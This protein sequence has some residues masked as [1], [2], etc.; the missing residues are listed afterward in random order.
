VETG[1]E[2]PEVTRGVATWA[3]V[4]MAMPAALVMPPGTPV[5]AALVVP[6]G[7][8]VPT[9]LVVPPGTPV[10]A[11]LVVPPGTSVPTALVVPPMAVMR[12]IGVRRTMPTIWPV[13]VMPMMAMVAA[14][15]GLCEGGARSDKKDDRASDQDTQHGLVPSPEFFRG[16]CHGPFTSRLI[17]LEVFCTGV[18]VSVV[19]RRA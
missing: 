1:E 18:L 7:T 3:V 16:L 17:Y 14:V 5:P 6:P 10:P 8:S 4:A 9:A 11:A 19:P 2:Y 13:D 12:P 15:S